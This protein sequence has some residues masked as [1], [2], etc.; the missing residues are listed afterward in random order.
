MTGGYISDRLLVFVRENKGH[1][2]KGERLAKM[3]QFVYEGWQMGLVV[4]MC[5]GGQVILSLL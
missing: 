4:P 3:R 1:W 5:R 2:K